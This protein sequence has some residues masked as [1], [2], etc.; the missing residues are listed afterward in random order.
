MK[1]GGGEVIEYNQRNVF[2]FKNHAQTEV[3]R[4][5]P[6]LFLFFKKMLYEVTAKDLR[7]S[8]GIF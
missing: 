5:V 3:A 6:G 7:L 4:L 1:F 2:F 8:F